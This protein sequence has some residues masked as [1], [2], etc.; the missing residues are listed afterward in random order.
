MTRPLLLSFVTEHARSCAPS[1]DVSSDQAVSRLYLRSSPST[2]LLEPLL[3]ATSVTLGFVLSAL[4]KKERK[5]YSLSGN[6][7]CT[8]VELSYPWRSKSDRRLACKA[9]ALGQPPNLVMTSLSGNDLRAESRTRRIAE[10]AL[11]RERPPS[12]SVIFYYVP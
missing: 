3:S 8:G 11:R 6:K 1:A 12:S 5:Q 4:L 2:R 9:V 10:K 7:Q